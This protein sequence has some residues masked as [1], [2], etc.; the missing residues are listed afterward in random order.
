MAKH[1]M[2]QLMSD[3]KV[4]RG[5]LG[6]ILQPIDHNLA[7]AFELKKAEGVL[8]AEVVKDSPAEK[9]GL[10]QGDIILRCNGQTVE[11]VSSFR[12]L[13]ALE[14][15]NT[16]L[17]LSLLRDKNALELTVTVGALKE[18][19]LT[20][21]TKKSDNLLGITVDNLT[22]DLKRSY[23]IDEDKGVIITQVD[24]NGPAATIGIKKGTLIISINPSKSLYS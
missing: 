17:K 24:P 18:D 9:A 2:N 16:N 10:K 4:T 3:G 12:N 19:N 20:K 13:I 6:V 15:P 7:K 21:T 8:I 5:Y 14:N 22:S 23:R 11:N 1:V